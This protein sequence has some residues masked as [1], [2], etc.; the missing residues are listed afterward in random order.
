MQGKPP[1]ALER[2]QRL[3][4]VLLAYLKAVEDGQAPDRQEWL[5]RYPDLAAELTAFFANQDQ[6]EALA[7]PLRLVPEETST[8]KGAAARTQPTAGPA[9]DAPGE[10]AGGSFGDF[11]LLEVIGRGGMGVVYRARH[12]RLQR[13]VAL[14]MI[15]VPEVGSA[16]EVRRFRNEAEMVAH[17]D[18]PH[19][20]PIYEVGEWRAGAD[21]PPVPY[22]SMKLIDGGRLAG[23][24][25]RFGADPWSAARLLAAVARAVHHAH[26]RGILHRDLKPGNILLD[27]AGQPHVTDFGLA[28][29]VAVDSSLTHSGELVGTPSY[30]A[31]EQTTGRRGAITTATDVYGLGAILYA[32]LT[33]RP[34]FRGDTP[35]D[36]L[37]QVRTQEPEKP[38]RI[39]PRVDRDLETIC[40][41]CLEKEPL[42]RY[43]SAEALAEDLE[44]W[45]AGEPI[46]ARPIRLPVRVWRWCRRK[47]LVASLLAALI[48]VFVSGVAGVT[49]QWRQALSQRDKARARFQ[50]A[51]QAVDEFHTQVSVSPELKAHPLEPLRHHLLESAVKFYERFVQEE[52]DDE[53]VQAEQGRAYRRLADL[54]RE[55]GRL[56]QAEA[57]YRQAQDNFQRLIQSH[58]NDPEYQQELGMIHNHLGLLHSGRNHSDLAREAYQQAQNIFQRLVDDHPEEPEHQQNLGKIYNNLG[59]LYSETNDNDLA[60]KAFQQ[61]LAIKKGLAEAHPEK[62]SYQQ[63]LVLGHMNLGNLYYSTGRH[64]LAEQSYQQAL[65]ILEHPVDVPSWGP[66]HGKLLARCHHNLGSLYRAKGDNNRAERAYKRARTLSQQLVDAHPL[67]V[68]YR[69]DLARRHNNLGNLYATTGRIELAIQAFQQVRAIGQMLADTNPKVPSFQRFLAISHMSLGEAYSLA[70]QTDQAEQAHR[71]ALTIY[72]RLVD[73]YPEVADYA[74]ELG[75]LQGNRGDLLKDQDKVREA[76]D[77][78]AQAIQ[79]LE[80]VHRKE[81]RHAMARDFLLKIYGERAVALSKLGR[82]G[83][84]EKDLQRARA[85]DSGQGR[86][87]LPYYRAWVL[88]YS[89]D[90]VRATAAAT[91]LV[92][93]KNLPD[94]TLYNLA[95]VWSL[96]ASAAQRDGKL[97]QNER[98]RLSES[99]ATTAVALL[100]KAQATGY[101]QSPG[102]I[103]R[104]KKDPDLRP[105]KSRNDFLK[106]L[107]ELEGKTPKF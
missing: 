103:E 48:L 35:L 76:L 96:A 70:G 5:A 29:R 63:D 46:Q 23:Q 32:L 37:N 82:R 66:E 53:A 8:D 34:P 25:A 78:Y 91:E 30:M 102:T 6:F 56:D 86:W 90:H 105:L 80:A 26:Q 71:Q 55:L 101:F 27:S 19:I 59:D 33:E 41:K 3:D 75:G 52:A 93:D 7:G 65:T 106:L 12:K 61:A 83:D 73:A 16:D 47:P 14:K 39:N 18:H 88:V 9:A 38:S 60:E 100:R 13:L 44:R 57:S 17:L 79:R 51:R 89:G 69:E 45:L 95:C 22:F 68:E 92:Q 104:M 62:V 58:P 42:R 24:L 11:E 40:L 84:A 15:R 21:S 49:W 50:M 94:N 99:Y 20:V 4:Q 43:P 67:V 97:L 87:E 64:H 31:P 81:P 77:E 1:E 10:S 2:E 107:S 74:V 85:F 36:T 54:S 28:K 72:Q 98:T